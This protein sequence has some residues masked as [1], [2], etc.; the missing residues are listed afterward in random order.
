[1]YLEADERLA[2]KRSDELSDRV[3][4]ILNDLV[5]A[6]RLSMVISGLSL[7]ARCA[8]D[9]CLLDCFLFLSPS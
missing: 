4:V 1:M 9:R 3:I 7:R 5:R 8:D 6:R 2:T